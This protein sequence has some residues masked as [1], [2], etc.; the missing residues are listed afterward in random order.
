MNIKA[1]IFSVIAVLGTAW[2]LWVGYQGMESQQQGYE[3]DDETE[4]VG[5]RPGMPEHDAVR[6]IKQRGDILSLDRI[7]QDAHAQHAGRVLESELEQKDGRYIYEVEL[8]DDQGRV[9]EM[10]FDA[11]TGEVLRE[12]QG[13]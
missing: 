11:S 7:L 6:A 1:A 2:L 8:V 5:E 13:D 4:E 12:K 9:R 3:E 10:K